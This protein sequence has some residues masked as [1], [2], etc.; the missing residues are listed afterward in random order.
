MST[1]HEF[2][3]FYCRHCQTAAADIELECVEHEAT[4][5]FDGP[6]PKSDFELRLD[7]LEDDVNLL[8]RVL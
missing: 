3:A 2:R 6:L 1:A 7:R 4:D 5:D 8:K